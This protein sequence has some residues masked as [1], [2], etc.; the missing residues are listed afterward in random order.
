VEV[1]KISAALTMA[2]VGLAEG[3]LALRTARPGKDRRLVYRN[4]PLTSER[5]RAIID[6]AILQAGGYPSHTIVAGGRQACDPHEPGHGPLR[7]DEPIVLN[8]ISKSRKTGYHAEITRT[9][10]KGRASDAVRKLYE[11]VRQAHE[12]AFDKLEVRASALALHRLVHRFFEE[13]GYHSRSRNGRIEGFFH[14]TGHGLGLERHETPRIASGTNDR[15]LA[16]HVLTLGPGLAWPPHGAV[17]LEDVVQ[18]AV[19]GPRNLTKFEK[20]LEL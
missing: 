15:L 11:T 9:I 16:G 1:K 13:Q 14:G 17:R 6:T 10:V 2:E 18:I 19:H 20:T 3:L 7:A 4:A 12:L 8:V 5:V